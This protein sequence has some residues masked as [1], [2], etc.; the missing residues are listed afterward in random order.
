MTRVPTNREPTHPGEMLQLEFL[1]PMGITQ[2]ALADS[3]KV[4]YQRVNEIVDG[5]HGITPATALRLSK[6]FGNTADFW[7]N[8]QASWDLYHAM[9]NEKKV[10][11]QIE[12]VVYAA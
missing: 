5:K 6:F 10:L 11:K 7:L 3:I 8:L 12:Q 4:S 2:R 9:K 1:E